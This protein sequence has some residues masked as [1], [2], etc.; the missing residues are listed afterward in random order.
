MVDVFILFGLQPFLTV[1]ETLDSAQCEITDLVLLSTKQTSREAHSLEESA[2]LS[3][4]LLSPLLRFLD[5]EQSPLKTETPM[6]FSPE[7]RDQI[8]PTFVSKTAKGDLS[9]HSG[10][11][12]IVCMPSS[13]TLSF[14]NWG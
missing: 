8:P 3:L 14:L 13:G 4:R 12:D 7:L 9:L 10:G 2:H 1:A 6:I 5:V 11:L